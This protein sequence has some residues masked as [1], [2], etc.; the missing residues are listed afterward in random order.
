MKTRYKWMLAVILVV[1]ILICVKSCADKKESDVTLAYIGYSFADR[2]LFEE[3]IHTLT[4][5]CE[6]VN[7]DGEFRVDLTEISFNESLGTADRENSTAKLASA[8][9]MGNARL[10]FIAE[11][12]VIRNKT[13]GVFADLSD[14]GEGIQNEKGETI[15]IS[16]H[17]NEKL[18]NIGIEP[19]ENMYL[20]IRIVSEMDE[21]T[22][23]NIQK[24]DRAVWTM[25]KNILS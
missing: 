16:V 23:K 14:L 2:T 25:A 21:V 18:L 13:A 7:G 6:D 3:N 24:K 5:G 12:Y 22:D 4:T 19:D 10:Y 11:D 17:G 8:V 9:G 15:A 1:G 20:A